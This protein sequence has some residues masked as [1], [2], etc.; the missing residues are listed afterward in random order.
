MARK[1]R[2]TPALAHPGVP[3]ARG[4]RRRRPAAALLFLLA[5]VFSALAAS[6][7]ADTPAVPAAAD[8]TCALPARLAESLL[9]GDADAGD[10]PIEAEFQID[11]KLLLDEGR[12]QATVEA[13]LAAGPLAMKPSARLC[14]FLLLDTDGE[15]LLAQQQPLALSDFATLESLRYVTRADLPEGT[16]SMTA[17]FLDA[18]SGLWGAAPLEQP[19][20]SIAGPGFT[21]IRLKERENT[22][23]EVARRKKNVAGSA[24]ADSQV[25][26]AAP[27][28]GAARRRPASPAILR[29]Q[30][31]LRS[32]AIPRSQAIRC[33]PGTGRRR[34]SR[35]CRSPAAD[36]VRTRRPPSR[37]SAST[38]SSGWCRRA[39]S[40]PAA[41]PCSIAW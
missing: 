39:S 22:W 41:R 5:S 36:R 18:E 25:A 21:A 8:W 27:P 3:G 2:K 4:A 34:N 19:A 12:T 13:K 28:A 15:A 26:A 20:E 1:S 31:I 17:I 7:Q 32:Q 14:F 23:V 33:S 37:G 24:P 38:R 40:R 29:G 11:E 35:R 6:V 16:R 9:Q 10:L 30:A